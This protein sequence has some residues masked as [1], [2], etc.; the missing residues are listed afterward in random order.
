MYEGEE[1][2]ARKYGEEQHPTYEGEEAQ[3]RKY[4]SKGV[5]QDPVSKSKAK[6]TAQADRVAM[7]A[8]RLKGR[9]KAKMPNP[10]V[11]ESKATTQENEDPAEAL[12]RGTADGEIETPG[13]EIKQPAT[14]PLEWKWKARKWS[15][16]RWNQST[17]VNEGW[18]ARLATSTPWFDNQTPSW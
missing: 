11:E 10:P 14:P 12:Q 2:Q 3:A 13:N 6:V 18:K 7:V 15:S 4:E 8:A 9:T 1:E 5:W 16:T 17:G